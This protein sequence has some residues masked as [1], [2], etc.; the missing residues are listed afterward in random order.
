MEV[1]DVV[2]LVDI[3]G[4]LPELSNLYRIPVRQAAFFSYPFPQS[5]SIGRWRSRMGISVEKT[6]HLF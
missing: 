2:R 5:R 3:G 4:G 6:G 1:S